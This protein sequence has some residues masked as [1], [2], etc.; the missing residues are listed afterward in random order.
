MAC[1]E[2]LVAV[3]IANAGA[4]TVRLRS[5]GVGSADRQ[6]ERVGAVVLDARMDAADQGKSATG[7][8]SPAANRRS[9]A[10]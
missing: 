9:T 10:G 8:Q 2:G 4:V 3:G 7:E 6:R 1:H 5:A